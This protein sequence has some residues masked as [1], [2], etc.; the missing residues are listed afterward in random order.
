MVRNNN[1][2]PEMVNYNMDLSTQDYMLDEN[3]GEIGSLHFFSSNLDHLLV[4]QMTLPTSPEVHKKKYKRQLL[5]NAL[6]SFQDRD[7]HRLCRDG[8]P[9]SYLFTTDRNQILTICEVMVYPKEVPCAQ[10]AF[11]LV[12]GIYI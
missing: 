9:L 3:S 10:L 5:V 4:L 11:C 12:G 2:Y 1:V 8:E 6:F 7:A